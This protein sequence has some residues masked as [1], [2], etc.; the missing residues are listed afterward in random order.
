M[1]CRIES[2]GVSMPGGTFF[3]R[4]SVDHA[5]AAGKCCIEKSRYGPDEV[6]TLINAGVFRDGHCGEPAMAAF[7]QEKL[8]INAGFGGTTSFSFDLI[9]GGVGMLSA[10]Q[11]TDAL[12]KSGA[13]R[14]GM[15]VASDVNTDA[16]PAPA[17]DYPRSGA[18]VILDRSPDS[19]RGFGSFVFRTFEE[20]GDASTA[21]VELFEKGGRLRIE[22]SDRLDDIY[23]E[24]AG[25]VF[26]ELLEREGLAAGDIDL[27]VPSQISPRFL[28][29]LPDTLGVAPE[30]VVNVMDETGGDTHTTSLFIAL[31]AAIRR[32]RAA[33]GT[34][35]AFLAV[36]SGVTVGCALYNF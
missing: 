25:P 1:R 35:A 7:I 30:A 32:G 2:I 36:G 23:L 34:K 14:V 21:R 31:K 9:N 26:E 22:K 12:M 13:I 19:H 28:G 18:A 5:V 8:G 27:V 4:G 3:N 15:A 17:Y 24:C 16:R 10:I 6:Q 29:G 11:V 33:R 20:H